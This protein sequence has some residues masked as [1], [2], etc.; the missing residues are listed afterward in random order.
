MSAVVLLT[1][2]EC[3][4]CDHAKRILRRLAPEYGLTIRELSFDSHEGRA[5]A[6]SHRLLFAPGV[7]LDGLP[8]S[9]GR[10]SE[11]RLRRELE[12]RTNAHP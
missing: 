9:Y 1:Q 2:S 6:T 11:R 7:V 8:F 12:R 4:L 10:L 3:D 5:L